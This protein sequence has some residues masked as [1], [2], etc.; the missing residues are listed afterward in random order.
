MKKILITGGLGFIGTNLIETLIKSKKYEIINLDKNSKYSNSK[1]IQNS[2]Y[3]E[4]IKINLAHKDST[5]I[6][7]DFKPNYIFHL[8]LKVM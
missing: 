7:K 3:Y 1:F 8:L 5:Y 2:T 4:Y 6:I